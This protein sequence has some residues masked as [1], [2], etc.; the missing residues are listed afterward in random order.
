[1]STNATALFVLVEALGVQGHFSDN[2]FLLQPG[3]DRTLT[4]KARSGVALPDAAAFKAVLKVRSLW[5]S[6]WGAY[7]AKPP[8]QQ[9]AAATSA[10]AT[11]THANRALG[12]HM[13]TR[14][15]LRG[16]GSL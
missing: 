8:A 10:T 4:F 6:S 13:S 5:D 2:A 3:K 16:F 15:S 12:G 1:M 7:Y 9:Q 11:A 14:S